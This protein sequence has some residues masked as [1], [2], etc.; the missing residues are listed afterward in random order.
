[1][2]RQAETLLGVREQLAVNRHITELL[3]PPDA[4]QAPV[5]LAAAITRAA[6]GDEEPTNVVVRPSST[7]G[8]R[9]KV[10]IAACGPPSA[11]LLVLG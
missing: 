2:S 11:A 10:R 5:G 6:T 8:V 9:L 3:I 7:F 4:E 1:V